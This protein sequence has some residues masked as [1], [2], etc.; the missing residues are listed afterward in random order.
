MSNPSIISLER[1][2][3]LFDEYLDN[4]HELISICGFIFSPSLVL[5]KMSV[6]RYDWQFGIWLDANSDLIELE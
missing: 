4:S 3:E 5:K 1:A 2:Y 6:T